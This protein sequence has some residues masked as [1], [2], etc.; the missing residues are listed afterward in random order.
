MCVVLAAAVL[1]VT[2]AKGCS[3]TGASDPNPATDYSKVKCSTW[4]SWSSGD[5]DSAGVD[6]A[7]RLQA[8][9]TSDSFGH[10]FATDITTDCQAGP[11]LTVADV[12]AG[13]ATLDT[14]DF[15]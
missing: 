12:A 9:D 15:N 2:G 7:Q 13:I 8:K 10:E 5:R 4:L 11:T 1:L 6:L 3:S 14:Q